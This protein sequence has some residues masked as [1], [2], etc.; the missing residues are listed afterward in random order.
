MSHD[1][2]STDTL[3]ALAAFTWERQPTAAGLAFE[4]LDQFLAK[5]SETTKLR[6]RLRDE[7]GNRLIDF[8][9]S[10]HV[11]ANWI[12]DLPQRLGATGFT[13]E[14]DNAWKHPEGIFPTIVVTDQIPAKLMFKVE[15]VLDFAQFYPVSK[16]QP[17]G[18]AGSAYRTLSVS[19]EGDLELVAI[20]RHGWQGFE[21]SD[22]TDEYLNA[23]EKHR[24]AFCERTRH[25]KESA[26]GFAHTKLLIQAAVDELGVERACDLFFYAERKYW[27]GRNRAAQ[28]QFE[29]Q[30]KLG[31][32]WANHD[33]HTYRSSRECFHLLIEQLEA[34]GF[35]CRER[36]YAGIEAGWGAQVLEQPRAGFVIFADVDMTPDEITGDFAHLGLPKRDELGTVGLWCQLHGEAYLEAGMHHLECQFDFDRAREQLAAV[37]IETMTPFTNF[38]HLRQAFTKGEQWHVDPARIEVAL[39]AGQINE[40]QAKQFR[41]DGAIG[42]HLEILERN[43]GY[44]GF[45]QTGVSDIISRTDPR[46]WAENH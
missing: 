45:N 17:Q 11:P 25:H 27:E 6:D 38:P 15:S 2:V 33:H 13:P 29:R 34:L 37:G 26:A 5:S 14:G 3:D 23:V 1:T 21:F 35:H 40:E 18:T 20:E 4:L 44:K 39:L 8:V 30:Q 28:V 43:D 32:G 12:S 42:S 10:F 46:K 31:L 22:E 9:D 7:T 24:V 36:F 19:L 16:P 41:H